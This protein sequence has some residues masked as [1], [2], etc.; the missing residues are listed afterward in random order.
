MIERTF[1]L[2]SGIGPA[3]E[4]DLWKRGIATWADFPDAQICMSAKLDPGMREA[5]ARARQALEARD[6]AA[7]VS[8]IPSRERWRLFPAFAGDCAYL[9]IE[10]DGTSATCEVTCIGTLFRG[11][12]RA[13]VNGFNL[14]AFPE[15]AKRFGVLV[16]FNGSCFDVPVLERT[17]RG[18]ELPRAHIDLRFTARGAGVEGG[19]KRIEDGLGLHRPDHLRGVNGFEAVTLWRDWR[20]TGSLSALQ[21]LV[22]YNLYDAIQLKPVLERLYNRQ[23]D[24]GLAGAPE[25][26]ETER[27][28]V[29]FDVSRILERLAERLSA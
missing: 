16:T 7:L 28:D 4:K 22:E 3:R 9:D 24:R 12:V 29:L 14:E 19:L 5:I 2:L 20:D 26:P 6:A 10:T 1:Q 18:L 13:F 25:H 11:E 21:R 8:M 27:G 17:F 15:Y 23:K